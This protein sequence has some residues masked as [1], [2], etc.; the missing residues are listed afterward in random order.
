MKR[1]E[2]ERTSWPRTSTDVEKHADVGFKQ[3]SEGVKEPWAR[4]SGSGVSERS[5]NRRKKDRSVGLTSMTV[6]LFGV[7]LLEAE[8]DLAGHDLLALSLA[9]VI[10]VCMKGE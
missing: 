9:E 3:G 6:D 4:H 5:S 10:V 2:T 8:D 1:V 7:V